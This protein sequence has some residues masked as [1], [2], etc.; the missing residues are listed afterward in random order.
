MK[1]SLF[2]LLV[3][4][5]S[6]NSFATT[7]EVKKPAAAPAKTTEAAPA[8]AAPATSEATPAPAPAEEKSDTAA[9]APAAEKSDEAKDKDHLKDDTHKKEQLED[10]RKDIHDKK[11][12][13]KKD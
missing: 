6:C 8:P 13:G 9:P 2:I 3:G 12:D 1:K 10:A 11:E 5:L 7:P 4:I